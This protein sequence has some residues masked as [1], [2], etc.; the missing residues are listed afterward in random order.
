MILPMDQWI[1]FHILRRGGKGKSEPMRPRPLIVSLT[2]FPARIHAVDRTIRSILLQSVKPD[3]IVLWLAPEQFPGR[4]RDLPVR[5]LRLRAFGLSIEWYPDI[6][7]YKKLIPALKAYPDC[8]IVTADDDMLYRREWLEILYRTYLE[9]PEFVHCHRITKF[10]L[11]GDAFRIVVGGYDHYTEPSF[12]HKLTGC[13]G[14]LYPPGALH[15]DA[16]EEALARS[17]APTNDDIWFWL[18]AVRNGVRISVPEGHMADLY[19]VK[20]TQDGPKLSADNDGAAGLFWA[21]FRQI[22]DAYPSLEHRLREEAAAFRTPNG[23][24][25]E[26]S[27]AKDRPDPHRKHQIHARFL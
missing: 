14:V 25:E 26:K 15:A 22:L 8:V 3:N 13:G 16:V 21:Q 11:E 19:Y 5:L 7:S 2:S 17:L 9:K 27:H 4:E 23:A 1:R 20:S 6:R 10:F 24:K 12:L 18:M